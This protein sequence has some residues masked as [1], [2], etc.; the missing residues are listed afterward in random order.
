MLANQ[1]Y[2]TTEMETKIQKVTK[3]ICNN[4]MKPHEQRDNKKTEKLH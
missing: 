2:A 4:E 3:K 1:Q